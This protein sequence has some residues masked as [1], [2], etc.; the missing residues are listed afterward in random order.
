LGF[1]VARGFVNADGTF[2]AN[3]FTATRTGVGAYVVTYTTPFPGNPGIQLTYGASATPMFVN[4]IA[5]GTTECS[6]TI[7]NSVGTPTDQAFWF[8]AIQRF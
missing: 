2:S 8:T 3:G 1:L 5:S 6:F 7:R 4:P